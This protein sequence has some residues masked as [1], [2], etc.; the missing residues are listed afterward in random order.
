MQLRRGH[1]NHGRG[2]STA[3]DGDLQ[4]RTIDLRKRVQG[5]PGSFGCTPFGG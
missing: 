2:A 4:N 3:V 1:F 5:L